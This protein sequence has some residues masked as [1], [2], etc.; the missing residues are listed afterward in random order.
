[1]TKDE[2]ARYIDQ[3]NLKPGMTESFIEEFSKKAASQ[4]FASVCILPNMVPVAARAL[5]GTKTKVCTVIS[6]PLGADVPS[7]KI[8]E[9]EDTMEKGAEE[10]DMVINVG[11]L[12]SGRKEI[13]KEELDGVVKAAHRRGC[14]VKSIIETPLL[15]EA[16]IREAAMLAEES[17]VDI[18]KTSTG[19]GPILK[20]ST[21][22]EDVRLIRSV[23]KAATGLKAAGGI[24]TTADA[25]AM[26]EA[27]ATRIGASSGD[28]IVSGL[29]GLTSSR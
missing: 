2:L 26:I 27:G 15:T 12:K 5:K 9:A 17:G 8:A 24:R 6:F 4:G 22:V 25:L 11:A 21:T 28:E 1:M 10:I 20:R 18:V 29:D 13:V 3:T 7:V 16:Q 14:I 23:I 19:F